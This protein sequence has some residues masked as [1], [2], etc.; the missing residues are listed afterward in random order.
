MYC[1]CSQIMF[2]FRNAMLCSLKTK[3]IDRGSKCLECVY[4]K[5]NE[6]IH[7]KCWLRDSRK[8]SPD[9]NIRESVREHLWETDEIMISWCS[10]QQFVQNA[11]SQ[12]GL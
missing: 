2:E 4:G 7:A 12:R 9:V 10:S 5:E 6:V 8:L 11:V 3:P 1:A